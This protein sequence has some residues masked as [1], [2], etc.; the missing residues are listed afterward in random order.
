MNTAMVPAAIEPDAESFLNDLHL[1]E[2][3]ALAVNEIRKHFGADA[4]ISTEFVGSPDDDAGFGR[5]QVKIKSQHDR[6]MF[7]KLMQDV[8][9]PLRTLKIYRFIGVLRDV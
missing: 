1:Q 9:A 4:T 5:L 7:K 3:Y 6:A 2:E 8:Y